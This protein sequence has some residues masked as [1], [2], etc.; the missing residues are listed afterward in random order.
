MPSLSKIILVGHLKEVFGGEVL[1]AEGRRLSEV[2]K[3]LSSKANDL[4]DL[5]GKPSG[6]YVF[7]INGV[8]SLVYGEDPEVSEEDNITIV[9]ISH[10]G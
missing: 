5:D 7:L 8:D 2:L 10:G 1:E 4:L 6:K 9:P 3:F